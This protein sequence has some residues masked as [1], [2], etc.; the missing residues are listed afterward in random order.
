LIDHSVV[1]GDGRAF[2]PDKVVD[3]VYG[4]SMVVEVFCNEI[5]NASPLCLQPGKEY[6]TPTAKYIKTFLEAG[7]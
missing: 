1:V 5:S 3:D 4:P 7:E 6:L 2:R